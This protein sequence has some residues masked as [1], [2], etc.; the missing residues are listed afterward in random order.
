[1]RVILDTNVFISGLA[2]RPSRSGRLLEQWQEGRFYLLCCE[3]QIAEIRRVSRYA[4]L[5]SRLNPP[6]VGSMVN[7]IRAT[8]VMI[9]KLPQVD[10]SPDP[11]DNYLLAMAQVGRA[12]YL[13]T[14]DKAD[15]LL[16]AS[17]GATRIVTVREFADLLGL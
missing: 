9:S 14:G 16:L 11:F 8:A 12:D 3:E 6:R 10:L 17:H 1:M 15:L 7:D 4:K 5:T 2:S 13:V